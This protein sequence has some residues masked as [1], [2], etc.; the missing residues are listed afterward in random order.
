MINNRIVLVLGAG[1]SMPYQFPS[2]AELKA[3]VQSFGTVHAKEPGIVVWR[4]TMPEDQT[5]SFFAIEIW[6]RT[7]LYAAVERISSS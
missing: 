5:S 6:N 4:A 1:A 2:G 3:E 7:K